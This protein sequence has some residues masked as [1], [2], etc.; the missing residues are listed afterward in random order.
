ML[1]INCETKED[2]FVMVCVDKQKVHKLI[3]EIK[4][5][6]IKNEPIKRA[7]SCRNPHNLVQRNPR[8]DS[9]KTALSY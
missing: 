8:G 3:R 6:P 5:R 4:A 1:K 9:P 2:V 7:Y